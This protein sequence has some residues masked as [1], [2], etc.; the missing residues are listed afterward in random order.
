MASKTSR[1]PGRHLVVVI[2]ACVVITTGCQSKPKRYNLRGQ[3]V[4][5]DAAANT[6]TVKHDDI[7]GF[8]SAMTMAY[9]VKDAGSL[10]VVEPG[11][12]ITAV[13]VTANQGMDYWL[14]NVRVVDRSGRQPARTNTSPPDSR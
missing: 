1:L 12:I 4:A 10:Q 13:V 5:K 7:P 9:P 14:E 2:L 11:D 6:L 8:M 3:V